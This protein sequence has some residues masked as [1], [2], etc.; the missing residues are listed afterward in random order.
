[1]EACFGQRCFRECTHYGHEVCEVAC[2]CLPSVIAL[3]SSGFLF[4]SIERSLSQCF[5]VLFGLHGPSQNSTKA[6]DPGQLFC[7]HTFQAAFWSSSDTRLFL[8]PEHLGRIPPTPRRIRPHRLN[9][10]EVPRFGPI[11]TKFGPIST[12]S[13][14]SSTDKH[15]FGGPLK[16]H[17][18]E[19][20]DGAERAA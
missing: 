19:F 14:P 8:T 9:V 10:T 3:E 2:K 18:A 4:S 15:E 5:V 7:K 11:P 13:G 6:H 1:M 20:H 16:S 12:K 17:Q